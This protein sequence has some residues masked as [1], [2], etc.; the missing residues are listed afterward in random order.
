[1][2]EI[3]PGEFFE[4]LL[5]DPDVQI[6]LIVVLANPEMNS[7]TGVL[8]YEAMKK[9]VQEKIREKPTTPST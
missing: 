4:R 6:P 7:D 2:P 9:A 8:A 3:N 1:M 5:Y